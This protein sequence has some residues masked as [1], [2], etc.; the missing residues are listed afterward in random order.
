MLRLFRVARSVL[1]SSI[2]SSTFSLPTIAW[3]FS[4]SIDT[5]SPDL[6]VSL[7]QTDREKNKKKTGWP[8]EFPILSTT[9]S[10]IGQLSTDFFFFSTVPVSLVK[11]FANTI[12]TDNLEISDF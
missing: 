5:K 11:F 2:N 6:S 9:P 4:L 12:E 7:C 8:V 3:K 10:Q 1:E